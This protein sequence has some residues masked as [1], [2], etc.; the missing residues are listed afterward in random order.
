M[1]ISFDSL[2]QRHI[3]E[4]VSQ[5]LPII[6]S[7][8]LKQITPRPD[9]MTEKQLAEYWQLRTPNGEI[10]V[11]SIRKWTARPDNEHPLPCGSMGEMRRYHREEVDKWAREEAARQRARN[12]KKKG[13]NRNG[14]HTVEEVAG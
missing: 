9:W 7:E 4:E 1:N 13:K 8:R 12:E 10:T 2:L 5:Q 3:A 14:L 11:H 6:V